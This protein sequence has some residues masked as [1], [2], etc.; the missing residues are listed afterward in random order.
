MAEKAYACRMTITPSLFAAFLKC[1]TQGWLRATG[2]APSGNSY[3][4]WV[5]SQNE[6]FRATQ[7]ERLI[8]ETPPSESARS[9][10]PEHL[11]SS[12][13]R[14]AVDVVA[15]ASAPA[16]SG[17]VPRPRRTPGEPPGQ[18]ADGMSA[19]PPD[20]T[21]RPPPSA[22][23]ARLQAV[24]R[25]PPEGRGKAAQF[26]PIRFVF[27]NKLTKDDKLLLAFDAFV[28]SAALGREITGTPVY[29][30]VERACP[31]AIS[32][33]SSA[34]ASETATCPCAKRPSSTRARLPAGPSV[35]PAHLCAETSFKTRLLGFILQVEGGGIMDYCAAL[36]FL[37]DSRPDGRSISSI[38]EVAEC[39]LLPDVKC[40]KNQFL[41][42]QVFEASMRFLSK[43]AKKPL[44]S[45]VPE[46]SISLFLWARDFRAR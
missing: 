19:L 45:L 15:Q 32:T 46:K 14:L 4:E 18:P 12:K 20:S 28:L 21:L 22:L 6:S 17:S 38:R 36:R 13:W 26:I 11:K 44:K 33:I 35:A 1:P 27:F 9:P 41:L 16:G 37:G 34:C 31:T 23:E 10:S 40:E 8:A 7:T 5:Q 43:A 39:F 29:L 3:A 30:D 42:G 24:E 2:E 25:V